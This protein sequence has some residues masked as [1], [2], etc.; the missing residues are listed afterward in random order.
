MWILKWLVANPHGQDSIE[1]YS[2]GQTVKYDCSET[3]VGGYNMNL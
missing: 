2:H 1:S 3:K